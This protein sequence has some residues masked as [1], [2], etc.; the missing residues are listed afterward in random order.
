M[1]TTPE[2]AFVCRRRTQALPF[3]QRRRS[4][5]AATLSFR[6][7]RN[8]ELS[9]HLSL[10]IH[11]SLFFSELKKPKTFLFISIPISTF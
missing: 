9:L 5:A 3:A 11:H 2:G 10:G 6:Y 7:N 1:Q 8:R 4:V